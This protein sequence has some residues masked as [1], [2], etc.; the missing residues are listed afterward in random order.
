M[1]AV[2][3]TSLVLLSMWR[4]PVLRRISLRNIRRRR[5]SALLVIA[6]SMVGIALIAGSMVIKD[7]THRLDQDVAYRYLGETDEIATLPATQ[8]ARVPYFDRQQV[9]DLLSVGRINGQTNASEGADLVDGVL[10]VAQET[11]PVQKV[12]PTTG[13][14]IL[15]E[16]RVVVTALD[17][18][19]LANFGRNPPPLVEPSSGEVLA[20]HALARELELEAGDTIQVFADN[21]SHTFR[22]RDVVD[23]QG[24]SGYWNSFDIISVSMLMRLEDAQAVFTGGEDKANAIF[25]S[26][27]GGVTDGFQHTSAVRQAASNLLG[28]AETQSDFQIRGVKA[29]VLDNPFSIGDMFLSVSS[30]AIVA[31][32][33]LV[34]NIYAMLAEERRSEMGIMRAMGLRRAHL[35]RLFLFEGTV[36]SLSA[37]IVG[38]LAGLGVARVA[39]WS[40]N[41]FAFFSSTD[42]S[43][44]L[45]FTF[46]LNS[47]LVA[48]AV[49]MV[50]TLATVLISS[51]RISN[52]NIVAAM[53]DLPEPPNQKRRRWTVVWPIL[54]AL[55]G[56]GLTGQAVA[57]DD[58]ILYVVGPTAAVLGLAFTLQ[59][60]LPSRALL[61][62]V[63]VGLV[64]YS[65]LAF[66]IPAVKEAND[67]GQAT[68]LTGMIL[69]L[70]AVGAFVLNFPAVVWLVR[71]SLGR[72]R[73]IL[74][75]VRL[76]LAYPAERPVRTGFTLGMFSL[77][78]FLETLAGIYL[79][80]VTSQT[81]KTREREMGG[82][83]AIVA[84]DPL[85]PV[86]D[87]KH[88]LLSSGKADFADVETISALRTVRVELP[89]Y[90]RKDYSNRSEGDHAAAS[91]GALTERII[92]LDSVFLET[93]RTELDMRAPEF[94]S[95]GE[96]WQA[97]AHDP[98][99]VVVGSAFDG[100]HWEFRRPVLTAGDT[101]TLRDPVSGLTYEKRI[102][103]R[104]SGTAIDWL[105]P[106]SYKE[107]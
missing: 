106:G 8:N 4:N 52:V 57:A 88:R 40:M 26:N 91:E 35:V 11:V 81:D 82:F 69:V 18:R 107:S 68:F 20:S 74:P 97:L 45:V 56:L 50:V 23:D 85:N 72:L 77:V 27:V 37:A 55:S 104:M 24:I 84:I 14:P 92:G 75:V 39:V 78:I 25:V 80:T 101:L 79:I 102:A 33:M 87:L 1:L 90:A 10:V 42:S 49:G 5:G 47:L 41:E 67:E 34:L 58:G 73:R 38:V 66:M 22:V 31:G 48:G 54:V 6:G 13:E 28:S 43:L 12:D 96:V 100:E 21:K 83:D 2:V 99:L 32:V 19:E 103:G 95:D 60:F 46:E 51:L 64:A 53:R 76:A 70:S 63:F 16:P 36:Y 29:Q 17:W 7:T 71:Q 105:L 15:V 3:G 93:T 62:L 89:Q 61:S 44:R 94:G 9:Q 86:P 59:R 98:S 65:Q 30:F